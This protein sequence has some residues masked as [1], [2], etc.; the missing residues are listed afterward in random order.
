MVSWR[1]P[2]PEVLEDIQNTWLI[3][4]SSAPQHAQHMS[5][6]IPRAF[7]F[8][9]TVIQPVT[10]CHRKCFNFGG[11]PYFPAE[12]LQSINCGSKHSRWSFPIWINSF[13]LIPWFN[14]ILP[15]VCEMP[16]IPVHHLGFTQWYTFYNFHI[17]GIHQN[18]ECLR[19]SCSRS[20][21]NKR[22]HC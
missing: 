1:E 2:K 19:I 11:A 15:I 22:I 7:R 20:R 17:L 14:R 13:Y 9:L 6:C 3:D 21:I 10:N 5:P 12:R 8:F 16:S 4:S 18:P